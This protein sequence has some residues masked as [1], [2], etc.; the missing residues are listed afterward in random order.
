MLCLFCGAELPTNRNCPNGC[1]ITYSNT[2][3]IAPWWTGMSAEQIQG[4]YVC[5]YCPMCCRPM[6]VEYVLMC[7]S[8]TDRPTCEVP[9]WV[10]RDCHQYISLE[11]NRPFSMGTGEMSDEQDG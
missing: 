9:W 11:N 7:T 2:T 6:R 8:F 5:R 10:C 1:S 3:V 4:R